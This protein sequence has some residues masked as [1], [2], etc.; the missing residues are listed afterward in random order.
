MTTT[1]QRI[2][3]GALS[4]VLVVVVS[5]AVYRLSGYDWLE[6]A[7]LV[8]V[9]IS[10]VGF[11]EHSDLPPALQ[12]FTICVILLGVSSG[13]YTCGG[14]IQM[15]LEGEINRL[16][17]KR[18]MT[19]EISRLSDHVVICGFGRLGSDLAE[20]LTHRSIPYVVVDLDLQRTILASDRSIPVIQGDATSE[21]VLEQANLK[22]ARALVTTLPSDAQNVFITLTARN[23]RPDIQIIAKSD[24]E[25][26]CRKLRQAGANRIVM[27]H[28]VA[29]TKWN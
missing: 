27:P 25:S 26:T 5:I 29:R 3:I 24:Q 16:L 8:V 23:M 12:V 14:F 13:V 18:K 9:T 22:T 19:K 17:G 7:W 2:R 1:L 20:R 28:Q 6:A 10:T 21:E 4:L 15:A 11:A